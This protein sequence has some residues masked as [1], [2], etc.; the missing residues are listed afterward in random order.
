MKMFQSK[1]NYDLKTWY[2]ETCRNFTSCTFKALALKGEV[3][4]AKYLVYFCNLVVVETSIINI[5][6]EIVHKKPIDVL[7]LVWKSNHKKSTLRNENQKIPHDKLHLQC[8]LNSSTN[9]ARFT[10]WPSK[11][12]GRGIEWPNFVKRPKKRGENSQQNMV[13]GVFGQA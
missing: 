3:V 2:L 6:Y 1:K 12:R 11:L 7:H 5:K 13:S 9:K 4:I 8:I 10:L